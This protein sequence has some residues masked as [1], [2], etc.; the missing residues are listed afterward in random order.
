M[1]QNRT[2]NLNQPAVPKKTEGRKVRVR[3]LSSK[4]DYDRR[5]Q[6]RAFPEGKQSGDRI[7]G[8]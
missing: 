3:D 4:G 8:L 7:K 2:L 6:P 1:R 5:A